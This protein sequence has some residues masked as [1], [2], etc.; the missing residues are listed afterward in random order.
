MQLANFYLFIYLLSFTSISLHLNRDW[1]ESTVYFNYFISVSR[2]LMI[3]TV[4]K[5]ITMLIYERKIRTLS[6]L[7]AILQ[8]MHMA[9]H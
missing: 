7:I 4:L 9:V 2:S 8:S 3:W 6:L 5:T 1:G